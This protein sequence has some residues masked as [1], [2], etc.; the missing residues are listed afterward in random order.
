MLGERFIGA[1]L[2]AAVA[3]APICESA[4]AC[5]GYLDDIGVRD[6][7]IVKAIAVLNVLVIEPGAITG[8]PAGGA[9]HAELSCAAAVVVVSTRS[10]EDDG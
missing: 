9:E 5:S 1:F 10:N 7:H 8:F 6:A 2:S 4:R 3:R